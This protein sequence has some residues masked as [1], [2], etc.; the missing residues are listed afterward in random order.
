MPDGNSSGNTPKS[1]TTS[2]SGPGKVF[3]WVSSPT[4]NSVVLT[5]W[6]TT[7]ECAVVQEQFKT[8]L[9][10]GAIDNPKWGTG[11]AISPSIAP[12]NR[13]RV[14][15]VLLA[16]WTQ[17]QIDPLLRPRHRPRQAGNAASTGATRTGDRCMPGFTQG[18]LFSTSTPPE[19]AKRPEPRIVFSPAAYLKYSFMCHAHGGHTEVGGYGVHELRGDWDNVIYIREFVTVRQQVDPAFCSLD[20]AHAN[21]LVVERCMADPDFNPNQLLA[22]WCHTHPSGS[23]TPSGTDWSTFDEH[24]A[25]DWAAMIILGTGGQLG[26]HIR[27]RGSLSPSIKSVDITVNWGAFGDGDVIARIRPQEWEEEYLRNVWPSSQN[28]HPDH[29]QT[30]TFGLGAALGAIRDQYVLEHGRT[31]PR[32]ADHDDDYGS[33]SLAPT[34]LQLENDDKIDDWTPKDLEEGIAWWEGEIADLQKQL[35]EA[36]VEAARLQ[37]RLVAGRIGVPAEAPASRVLI[38]FGEGNEPAPLIRGMLDDHNPGQ[39]AEKHPT[40]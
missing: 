1:G 6:L 21:E 2:G 16:Y 28:H 10:F 17:R 13:E 5:P 14:E 22:C 18:S 25:A 38:T 24:G 31:P 3:S 33:I 23:V 19:R 7:A 35:V 12:E 9:S 36:E 4:G 15:R 11:T 8:T 26:A 40:G 27:Q 20:P 29:R 32:G 39:P 34:R 30:Y 37:A